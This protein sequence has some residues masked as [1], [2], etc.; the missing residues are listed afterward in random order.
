VSVPATGL[1]PR[2]PSPL[3]YDDAEPDPWDRAFL[4]DAI[5][6]GKEL[7]R[8]ARGFT[9]QVG[10]RTAVDA[11]LLRSVLPTLA[12]D[13]EFNESFLGT[14]VRT[15]GEVLVGG[16]IALE[17]DRRSLRDRWTD[18]F[19]FRDD[20]A[21]WGLVA[22]DQQVKRDALLGTLTDAFGRSPLLFAVGGA[23]S[24]DG[25]APGPS[26]SAPPPSSPPTT[27]S[28]D[29]DDGD[30][31]DG[32]D[33]GDDTDPTVPPTTV[34]K[35]PPLLPEDDEPPDDER[36]VFDVVREVLDDLIGGDPRVS[37]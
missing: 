4:G 15:A 35:L 16:A 33:G 14:T 3:L 12:A 17:G 22:L 10:A 21:R 37:P 32:G 13:D 24:D 36:D 20:G 9:G 29:G 18:V 25:V 19:S 8:R 28:D 31:G 30:G 23:D 5:D 1:L 11:Q 26:T 27:P 7:D 6:L 34:P 2:E